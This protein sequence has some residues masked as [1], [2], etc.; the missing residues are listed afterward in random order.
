M[1]KRG[2]VGHATLTEIPAASFKIYLCGLN[3]RFPNTNQ[4]VS[5]W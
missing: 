3:Q 4:Y 5:C 2:L 1:G